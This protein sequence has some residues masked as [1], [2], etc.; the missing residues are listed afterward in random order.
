M[1][2]TMDTLYIVALAAVVTV[3]YYWL[4]ERDTYTSSWR[5]HAFGI[6]LPLVVASRT[7]DPV[8]LAI[9]TSFAAIHMG[10]IVSEHLS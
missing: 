3:I 10:S 8:I 2:L 1:V 9:V 6:G 7:Q 5:I 4:V